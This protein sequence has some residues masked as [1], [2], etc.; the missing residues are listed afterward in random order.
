[1]VGGTLNKNGV[2]KFRATKVGKE[3][4]LAQIISLVEEA[5]GSR[6]PIQR[7]ADRAVSYF[8]PTI[9]AIAFAA[10]AYW[11][12]VAHNTLLFSLTALISVLVVACPCALGLATPTAVTVGIG[13]G[14]ELGILI[15]S[16]EA[17]EASEKLKRRGLRQ[18]RHLT[19]G[20]PDVTDIAPLGMEEKELL[21]LAASAEK[22]SEHPLAEAVVRKAE[23]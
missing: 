19:V 6:P 17:L 9:L 3:T 11:Y 16:G 23:A 14:A 15:K 5:Q 20:R 2:L 12:F 1:M 7:I 4:A 13:R 18:D 8:I 10:F 21:R 22:G